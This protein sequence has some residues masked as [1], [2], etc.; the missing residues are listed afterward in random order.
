MASATP[1]STS[2]SF[3]SLHHFHTPILLKLDEEKFLLW[4]QQVLATLDGLML[5]HFLDGSCIPKS[6]STSKDGTITKTPAY[7][8]YK[9]HDNLLVA[10]LLASM[11]TPLLMQMV[12]LHSVAQI[13]TTLH[14]YFSS[15]TRSQIKKLNLN[16]KQ[17]KKD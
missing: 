9:Q 7:L 16:L 6:S 4:K 11:T 15:H 17:P 8:L 5:S 1:A 3:V 12:G 13:W 2:S 10:W 14:T